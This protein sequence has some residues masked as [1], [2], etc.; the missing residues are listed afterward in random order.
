MVEEVVEDMGQESQPKDVDGSGGGGG[1]G[2]GGGV[3]GQGGGVTTTKG[4]GW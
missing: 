2:G 3:G 1:G 4:C